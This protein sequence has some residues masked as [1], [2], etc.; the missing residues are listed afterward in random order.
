MSITGVSS[1]PTTTAQTSALSGG[2]KNVTQN[3]FLQLLVAQI[4][5]QDPLNPMDGTAFTAQLAQFSSLEQLYNVNTN[6]S[7]LQNAQTAMTNT[8]ALGYI[9]KTI[10]ATGDS[11]ALGQ[12][13]GVNLKFTLDAAAAAT[14]ARIYDGSG[15]LVRTLSVGPMA[16]GEGTMAWDG[17]DN[18][19]NRVAAGTYRFDILAMDN[20]GGQ[21][22]ATAYKTGA[23]TG[24]T[25]TGGAAAL[26]VGDEQV[27]MGDVVEILE[28]PAPAASE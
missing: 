2:K 7:A 20:A 1:T 8:Q 15:A 5:T 26:I 14:G 22:N 11:V 17:L 21:I 25:M 6:L 12:D 16:A 3:D 19:G 23:V 28:P 4:K 9:G 10:T 13:G 24:V 18:N 27:A